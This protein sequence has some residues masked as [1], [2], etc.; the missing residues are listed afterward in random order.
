MGWSHPTRERSERV[1]AIQLG[2]AVNGLESSKADAHAKGSSQGDTG[3][4]RKRTW[5]R[6]GHRN[7]TPLSRAERIVAQPPVAIS[8]GVLAMPVM[9][10]A[11]TAISSA[12][13]TL[14]ESGA[15]LR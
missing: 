11:V 5:V 13:G 14:N 9:L 6:S 4:L 15:L 1:G 10:I 8:A 3:R 12:L 7:R 2:S